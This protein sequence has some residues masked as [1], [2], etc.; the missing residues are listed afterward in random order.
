MKFS[1]SEFISGTL[2]SVIVGPA[3][4]ISFS[5]DTWH[6]S[7]LPKVMPGLLTVTSLCLMDLQCKLFRCKHS[8]E[9]CQKEEERYQTQHKGRAEGLY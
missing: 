2:R 5:S 9:C 4:I 3:K 8:T 7:I 6:M 1:Q